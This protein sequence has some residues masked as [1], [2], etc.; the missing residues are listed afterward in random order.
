M[1]WLKGKPELQAVRCQVGCIAH[2]VFELLCTCVR[3]AH[4]VARCFASWDSGSLLLAVRY[5]GEVAGTKVAQ[6]SLALQSLFNSLLFARSSYSARPPNAVAVVALALVASRDMSY[7]P[8]NSTVLLQ[9]CC[10]NHAVVGRARDA[11]HP[12]RPLVL[13]Y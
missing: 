1:F 4:C 3:A 7:R 5:T 6:V 11:G 12:G 10:C 9:P 2:C 8:A 13:Q